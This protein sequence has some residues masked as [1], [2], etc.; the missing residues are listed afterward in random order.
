MSSLADIITEINSLTGYNVPTAS[1]III[2]SSTVLT[3][4]SVN[5]I[6]NYINSIT[7]YSIPGTSVTY[8]SGSNVAGSP[9]VYQVP[10]PVSGTI[11]RDGIAPGRVIKADHILRIIDALDGTTPNLIV[12][13]GS[14]QVTGST[15]LSSSLTVGG[16]TNLNGPLNV[17]Q[18]ATFFGNLLASGSATFAQDLILPFVPNQ[19]FIESVSGSM[20]GTG[21]VD[22]GTF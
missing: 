22:G 19:N 11:S 21:T 10:T 9:I 15:N 12:M 14:L 13:S 7:G 1:G 18:L 5:D 2:S 17:Y 20:Q 8:T 4:G 16:T 6:V 3:S